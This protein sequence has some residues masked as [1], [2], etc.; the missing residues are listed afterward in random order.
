MNR[1]LKHFSLFVYLSLVFHLYLIYFLS[2]GLE[3]SF[4]KLMTSQN[5]IHRTVIQNIVVSTPTETLKPKQGVLSDKANRRSGRKRKHPDYNY[6]NPNPRPIKQK[7]VVQKNIKHRA[8]TVVVKPSKQN[9]MGNPSPTLFDVRKKLVVNMDNSGVGSLD[10]LP[11]KVAEYLLKVNRQ[12]SSK[13]HG[14][15]PVFQYYQGIMK[16]GEVKVYFEILPNGKLA[17]S[18]VVKSF[19][20]Q[21]MDQACLNAVRYAAPFEPF[22]KD[23]PIKDLLQ[24]NFKFIYLSH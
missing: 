6:V 12:I 15:F 2:A 19:G 4:K 7:S 24:I 8:G 5:S 17:D 10:T 9:E 11:S 16:E 22:P 3:N 20:Y 23:F 13:W 1:T 18:K 21:I 14:F